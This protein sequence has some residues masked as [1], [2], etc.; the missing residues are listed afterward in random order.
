[1]EGVAA[2]REHADLVPARELRE[3]D[4]ALG[5]LIDIVVAGRLERHGRQLLQRVLLDPLALRRRPRFRRHCRRRVVGVHGVG[6]RVAQ[7]RAPRDEGE[8]H[9]AEQEAEHGREDEERVRVDAAPRRRRRRR[10]GR[11]GHPGQVLDD[12]TGLQ[13]PHARWWE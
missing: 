8:P 1:M 13:V 3:A 2:R 6:R 4:G 12:G 9:D 7:P 5:P 10:R 11:G